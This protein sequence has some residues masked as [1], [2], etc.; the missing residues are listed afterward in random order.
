[1]LPR[2]KSST[3][4]FRTALGAYTDASVP[5]S[6]L[7]RVT[8]PSNADRLQALHLSLHEDAQVC[9]LL[10]RLPAQ[11]PLLH[12]LSITSDEDDLPQQ[13][14]PGTWV[15]TF[16]PNLR[17]LTLGSISL[18][19]NP[20]DE[21]SLPPT[22]LDLRLNNDDNHG[23]SGPRASITPEQLR[24]LLES[25]PS[26]RY[27]ELQDAVPLT[28]GA[29]TG[30]G[31][32]TSPI[33]S[34]ATSPTIRLPPTLQLLDYTA[35][36]TLPGHLFSRLIVPATATV[37]FK[38]H[39]NFAPELELHMPY[40]LRAVLGQQRA[41]RRLKLKTYITTSADEGDNLRSIH[42]SA[43]PDARIDGSTLDKP[44]TDIS[45]A[46]IITNSNDQTGFDGIW[47]NDVVC[48]EV[49]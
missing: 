31:Y 25:M 34:F 10:A 45:A 36:Y 3:L 41:A 35:Y 43:W 1:M 4:R 37:R 32:L 42:V 30:D 19:W 16:A 9:E 6:L 44:I 21:A 7:Q 22:L 17:Q 46:W 23:F 13:V 38:M 26:L 24:A 12:E 27:C 5:W 49:D 15:R 29:P 18:H 33:A 39:D 11:L 47:F 14:I 20:M 2:A 28:P 48:L 8:L 40:L